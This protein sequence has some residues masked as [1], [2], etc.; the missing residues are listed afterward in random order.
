[1]SG[2]SDV[3]VE[4]LFRLERESDGD[5]FVERDRIRRRRIGAANEQTAG[6]ECGGEHHGDQDDLSG[7]PVHRCSSNVEEKAPLVHHSKAV[8]SGR[9]RLPAAYS[10]AEFGTGVARS[11]DSNRPDRSES[12]WGSGAGNR[13]SQ[14]VGEPGRSRG[15]RRR[16][17]HEFPF[18][19]A[20]TSFG[21]APGQEPAEPA[22]TAR[23]D[24]DRRPGPAVAE[25]LDI[26][27]PTF[28]QHF[29][30]R[31]ERCS[32]RYCRAPNGTG[33]RTEVCC[34]RPRCSWPPADS[35]LAARRQC[36]RNWPASP[37][38][39]MER[40]RSAES[41]I[42]RRREPASSDVCKGLPPARLPT[43]AHGDCW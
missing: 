30:K 7:R 21:D 8:S 4:A 32:T 14:R 9:A 19:R 39:P 35:S 15:A 37:S 20:T 28:N 25:A 43:G 26:A 2:E 11:H 34:I 22:V 33:R 12:G 41:S 36:L 42:S 23:V 6:T 10:P 3:L 17:E 18:A 1:V 29:R 40:R 24:E 16:N 27:S 38:S 31:N 5:G 13:L